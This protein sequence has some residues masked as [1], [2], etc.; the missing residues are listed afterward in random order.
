MK[1]MLNKFYW[2]QIFV[3]SSETDIFFFWTLNKK[4]FSVYNNNRILIIEF[5]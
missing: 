1:I 4:K 2:K 3:Y 5:Y